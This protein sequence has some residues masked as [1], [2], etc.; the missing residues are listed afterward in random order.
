MPDEPTET[1]TPAT[2]ETH[3]EADEPVTHKELG[4]VVK[5]KVEEVL[6]GLGIFKEKPDDTPAPSADDAKDKAPAHQTQD[7]IGKGWKSDTE[8]AVERV[9]RD[10]EHDQQHQKLQQVIEQAPQE[11]PPG[12]RQKLWS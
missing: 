5:E 9:L 1:E 10:K 7:E 12:W 2:E 8:A 11:K 4:T 6:T 3:S